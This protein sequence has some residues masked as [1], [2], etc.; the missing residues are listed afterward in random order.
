M[1]AAAAI[2]AGTV[3]EA[4]RNRVVWL[5]LLAAAGALALARFAGTLA[6]AET[7]ALEAAVAAGILRLAAALLVI[8]FC[9][10][11]VAR[12]AQ[13]RRRDVYL[14]LP[15]RRGAYIG[16]KL[17]GFGLL[18]TGAAAA[19]MAALLPF[20]PAAA[21][22]AWGLT[23]AA[24]LWI[25]AAFAL[26]CASGLR[27]PLA[28]LAASAG[29]Y[30]LARSVGAIVLLA[31]Q[32]GGTGAIVSRMIGALLPHLDQFART[33]W[34]AYGGATAPAVLACL[35]QA[36]IYVALLGSAAAWD[37]ARKELE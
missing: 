23:L 21:C 4:R 31:A 17:M 27:T 30:L 11:G 2:A 12:E 32:R 13:E 18:A 3:L 19:A 29:F 22:I 26:F 37:L 33:D 28:A 36:V 14:A 34:L 7:R 25:C 20:A 10:Q 24:E 5:F 1:H 6:L 8:G 15:V 9:V 16:G 35:V